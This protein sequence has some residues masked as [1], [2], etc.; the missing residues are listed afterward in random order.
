[1]RK[2]RKAGKKISNWMTILP[3]M[4]EIGF[5]GGP[6]YKRAETSFK[7]GIKGGGKQTRKLRR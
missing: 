4:R 3:P 5:T 7:K 6:M 2:K 1:M